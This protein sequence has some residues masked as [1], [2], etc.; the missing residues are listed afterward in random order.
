MHPTQA[1][2]SVALNTTCLVKKV[3][4]FNDKIKGQKAKTFFG[5]ELREATRMIY[6]KE[7]IGQETT[8]IVKL[9]CMIDTL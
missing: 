1:G 8:I 4:F 5:V 7:I 9:V 3:I 2:I 6:G